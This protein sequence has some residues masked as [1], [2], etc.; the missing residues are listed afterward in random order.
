M[1]VTVP[2]EILEGI[3]DFDADLNNLQD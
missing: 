3:T 2:K 1:A